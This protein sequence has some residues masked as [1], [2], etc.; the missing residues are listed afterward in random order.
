[1]DLNHCECIRCKKSSKVY[2]FQSY[3]RKIFYL[4]E[5]CI[6]VSLQSLINGIDADELKELLIMP[7]DDYNPSIQTR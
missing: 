3:H 5:N 7:K 4:C 6:T 1:M 2:A